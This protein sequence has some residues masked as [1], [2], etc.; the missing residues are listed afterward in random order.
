MFD[1]AS[2]VTVTSIFAH[3]LT[4]TLGARGIERHLGEADENGV[5]GEVERDEHDRA[6]AV[7]P[8]AHR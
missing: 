7:V 2:F 1:V 5:R 6:R 4:D 8:S 3:G